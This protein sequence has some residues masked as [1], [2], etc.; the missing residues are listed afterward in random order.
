M[1]TSF[2]LSSRACNEP[3]MSRVKPEAY[4]EQA[5]KDGYGAAMFG[6]ENVERDVNG[7]LHQIGIDVAR[8]LGLGHAS[9]VMD[10]GCGDGALTNTLLAKH[11][12]AIDGFDLSTAAI[13]RA[14]ANAAHGHVRFASCDITRLDFATLP[15]YHGAFLWGILH[16]VKPAAAGILND[17]QR[18]GIARLVILEPNG[19]H[20]GRKLLEQTTSYKAA[21]EDSFST[22][23]LQRILN[24]AGYRT[25][26]RKSL[27]IF[28]NFTPKVIFDRLKP[29]E[30]FIE[31]NAMLQ[32]LCTVRI[33]GCL[34]AD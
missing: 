2:C 32:A 14:R 31:G 5:G 11:F 13:A 34:A 19:D 22:V 7:R 28:P 3:A 16:H 12:Q 6:D 21:G 23:H 20:W 10:L 29:I 18:V 27:N 8:Q 17:M 25:I 15:P 1:L 30:P 9:R 4:W 24:E 33:W 26:I